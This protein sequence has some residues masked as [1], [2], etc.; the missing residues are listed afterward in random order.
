MLKFATDSGGSVNTINRDAIKKFESL[1][2]VILYPHDCETP[3]P[4]LGKSLLKFVRTVPTRELW[5]HF[6]SLTLQ[7]R[8]FLTN[9][10]PV[11][12][13]LSQPGMNKFLH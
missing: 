7:H 10:R 6:I 5:Q 13:F 11:Y 2:S 8:V 1:M 9:L 4:I 3:L 12:V